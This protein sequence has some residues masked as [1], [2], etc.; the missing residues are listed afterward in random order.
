MSDST[1]L[2]ARTRW[3]RF[4]FGVIAPLLTA[5]PDKGELGASIAELAS[6]AWPHPTTG[7]TLRVSAK[8]IERWYYIA[9]EHERPLEALARKVS[10]HAGTHPSI[11]EALG[12]ELRQLRRDHPRWS[13]QLVYDNLVVI[14][15]QK[16]ELGVV[17]A[18]AT[19]RR[20]MKQHGLGKHR[21]P[22]RHEQ[23]PGFVP[24][25]KR[26]FEVA[27]VGA[28]WHCDFHGA[29]RKVLTA[30]GQ[31]SVATL[32]GLL[33]DR[34]RLCCHA[35]WYLGDENTESFVH[36][37][38]QGF[39]KRGL[40]RALLSDNGAPMLAAETSDGLDRLSVEHFTTLAQT[41]EQNGKQEVFW[42]QIEGRLMPM[43]EGEPELTLELL[44]RATQAWVEQEYNRRVH[45]ETRQ[46]PLERWLA[47]PSVGRPSP[48][49]DELRR[50]FRMQLSRKQRTSDG[51][52][53]VAGIRY[54]LPSA[55]R[56]LLRP[57][58]RVA[59][60]DL[61]SI[62]LVDP[63]RDVHLATLLPLDKE[64]NA[65]RRRRALADASPGA[66][67]QPAAAPIGIAPLLRQY[68][69][70]YAATGL[71]P[72]YVPHDTSLTPNDDN[73]P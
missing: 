65:D 35:Q 14:A 55:Y 19:V 37:L 58:V 69:A 34:S 29:K 72:A 64:R 73:D 12:A 21:R 6:R 39:Q 50:A 41:P 57:T 30:A 68:M 46:T 8:T 2:P 15:R 60:W 51:T 49:S 33:D 3:A 20:Y 36:G 25:E 32:F 70:D 71:P 9:R 54:E 67:V 16:P 23:A 4:R 47:G 52:L 11:S 13:Y 22:R 43:L 61:S 59:R 28:L 45:S 18:Y 1:R 24:R 5:P 48:S 7:E 40:P 27:H 10:R 31:W 62:D 44:N 17:P 63:R 53:T 66:L 26:S 42:A 38:S 56:T